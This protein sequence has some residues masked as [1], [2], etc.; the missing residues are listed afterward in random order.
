MIDVLVTG[1]AGFIGRALIRRLDQDERFRVHRLDHGIGDIA[2]ASTWSEL[3]AVAAVFHLAGRS[4]VPDSW[5]D[6]A[7]FLR[8]NTVGTEQAL[9][10][11]RRHHARLILPSTYVYGVPPRLPIDETIAPHPSNP[12]AMSKWMAEELCSFSHRTHGV[13]SAILRLFNVFGPG[14]RPEFLIPTIM[15]QVRAG[16]DIRVQSLSPRRDYV[17]L[18][19]VVEALIAAL[20]APDG[21]HRINIASGRSHSVQQIIDQIQ[22]VA[23]TALPV[24]SAAVERPQEIPDTRAD[25]SL[26]NQLLNWTPRWS[27]LDGLR[28]IYDGGHS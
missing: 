25:I 22:M 13:S 24:I 23:G 7:A 11:C 19:D 1:A 27:F 4:F 9:A 15:R 14:E 12:Y 16:G 21:C 3:P 10:Y 2:E 28:A 17:Y 20:D 26:A 6:P 5:Q 18:E 8:T